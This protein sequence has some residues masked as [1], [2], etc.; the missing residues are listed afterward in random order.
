[1]KCNWNNIDFRDNRYDQVIHL[2][3]SANGAHQYYQC[4]EIRTEGIG[5]NEIWKFFFNY[6][7]ID[8]ISYLI[9]LAVELDKLTSKAWVGHPNM[10]IIDNS[11]GF[12]EKI[13]RLIDV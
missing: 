13:D 10:S 2:V 8:I 5:S 11:T 4:S 7:P 3:S 6:K 12:E 9:E 1:M